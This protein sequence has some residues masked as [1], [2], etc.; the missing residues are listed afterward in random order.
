QSGFFVHYSLTRS[1]R[2]CV[3]LGA[4]LVGNAD[5]G[6][7]QTT[8]IDELRKA[9]YVAG[10]NLFFRGPICGRETRPDGPASFRQSAAFVIKILQGG[11]PED[12]PV[13]QPTRLELVI[14]LKTAKALGVT[15]ARSLLE[16]ADVV[17]E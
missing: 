12:M 9:G 17:I 2:R 13:E 7:F 4:L 1:N 16:R 5:V 8:L 11:I 3:V 6:P 14:N 15:I 10:Q